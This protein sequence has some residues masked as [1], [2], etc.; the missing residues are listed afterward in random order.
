MLDPFIKVVSA[1]YDQRGISKRNK[2]NLRSARDGDQYLI[3]RFPTQK[4]LN[5][6]KTT[7]I[8]LSVFIFIYGLF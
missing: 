1:G 8:V 5:L 7:F 4:P 3:S 6:E 2:I